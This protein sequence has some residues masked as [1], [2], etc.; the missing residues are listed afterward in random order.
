MHIQKKVYQQHF[1][2][3]LFDYRDKNIYLYFSDTNNNYVTRLVFISLYIKK[4]QP[5]V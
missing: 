5:D 3:F 2:F 4:G 1:L